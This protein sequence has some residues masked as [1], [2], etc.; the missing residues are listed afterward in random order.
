MVRRGGTEHV[1][2]VVVACAV[3]CQVCLVLAT[4]RS[5]SHLSAGRPYLLCAHNDGIIEGFHSAAHFVHLSLDCTSP[6]QHPVR[7]HPIFY[8]EMTRFLFHLTGMCSDM[9]LSSLPLVSILSTLLLLSAFDEELPSWSLLQSVPHMSSYLSP[10]C[11]CG[12]SS[13]T[14]LFALFLYLL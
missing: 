8:L 4:V 11:S 7:C 12:S 6:F 1:V 13:S 14:D 3:V 9:L 5:S 2:Q 10:S